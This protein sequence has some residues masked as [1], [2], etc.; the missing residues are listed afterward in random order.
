[1]AGAMAVIDVPDWVTLPKEALPFWRSITSARAADRWN[2][3]DLETAAE[4]ARTKAKIERLNIE[5]VTEGDIIT[6]DRGTPIVNPKNSLL[7]TLTRRLV[8][9][10]RMLQVHAEATQ[11]KSEKQVAANKTQ[12]RHRRTVEDL[13]GDDLI[14]MPSH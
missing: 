14:A 9:L 13:E 8:A 12:S 11:G 7:E 4:L 6:N 1:M 3:S 2:N 5:L 10:S